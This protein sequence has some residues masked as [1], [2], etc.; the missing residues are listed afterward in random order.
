MK[1][2]LNHLG[3]DVLSH[4]IFAILLLVIG[5]LLYFFTERKKQLNFFGI[6]TTK[7]IVIYLSNLRIVRGGSIGIDNNPRAYSGTTVVYNEQL[8]ASKF[9][10]RFNFLL[11]SLSENSSILNNILFADIK[12][13]ILP[14][15]LTLGEIDATTSLISFG[16]P[17]YNL[18]SKYIEDD[19]KSIVAFSNDMQAMKIDH[20][21]DFSDTASGFIQKLVDSN[22]GRCT[23]YTAGLSELGTIGAANYLC[24]NW[25]IL[26]EKY[27]SEKQFIVMLK[28]DNGNWDN[29]TIVLEREIP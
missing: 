29:W 24:S 27:G 1:E 14:S 23:F 16:S 12:V 21:S 20:V 8:V 5:W 3:L 2:S 25:K 9:K 19:R 13:T 7:R 28:F 17:G 10:E 11:P 26:H 4:F 6:K 15:P 18:T 22:S